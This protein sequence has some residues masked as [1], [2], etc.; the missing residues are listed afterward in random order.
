M[1][2]PIVAFSVNARLPASRVPVFTAKGKQVPSCPVPS[3]RAL[4][5]QRIAEPSGNDGGV[6]VVRPWRRLGNAGELTNRTLV[7]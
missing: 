7:P 2:R 4:S 6:R 5:W 3:A 1:E